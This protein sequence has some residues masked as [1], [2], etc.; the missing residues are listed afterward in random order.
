MTAPIL[1]V[2]AGGSGSRA[3]LVTADG[4]ILAQATA[5]PASA[6]LS[7]ELL[8]G[9][10][11]QLVGDLLARAARRPGA[12]RVAAGVAGSGRAPG[13]QRWRAALVGALEACACPL[14]ALDLWTDAEIAL[15][16]A[17]PTT[18]PA[19]I[20]I[21]GTG[22][23]ALARDAAGQLARVG[24]WG[25]E[26][27]DEGGGA[28]LGRAALQLVPHAADGRAPQARALAAAVL[29]H[30]GFADVQDLVA[31]ASAWTGDAARLAGVAPVI[32]AEAVAGGAAALALLAQ[33][34]AAL[35]ELV[36]AARRAVDLPV[37][38]PTTLTGGLVA[39][40]ASPLRAALAE[41]LPPA[42]AAGLCDLPVAPVVGA[43]CL[44]LTPAA[45]AAL[46]ALNPGVRGGLADGDRA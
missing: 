6:R 11:R 35:A 14:E 44:A 20:L 10:L 26:L 36:V 39:A 28:W 1:A 18:A 3:L 27:G 19:A 8:A 43:A 7:E 42:L 16:A 32:L 46:R 17:A 37:A 38:V 34:A 15:A 23:L 13:R 31:E 40:R 21:A 29:R 5:G 12:V 4:Q 45:G 9:T 22:T 33:A 30:C 2:D 41:A 25:P 24:G